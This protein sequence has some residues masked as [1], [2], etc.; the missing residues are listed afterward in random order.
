M[1]DETHD[2]GEDGPDVEAHRVRNRNIR[3]GGSVDRV[4][5]P[6]RDDDGPDV[7]AHIR[8]FDP[9]ERRTGGAEGRVH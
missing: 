7:E 3:A 1:S 4:R 9:S 8:Q 6:D 2:I 5:E